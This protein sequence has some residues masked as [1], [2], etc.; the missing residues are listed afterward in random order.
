MRDHRGLAI[1]IALVA[2]TALV[3]SVVIQGQPA[4]TRSPKTLFIGMD[5]AELE[6]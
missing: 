5:G 4:Q 2:V 6:R 1:V 3:F